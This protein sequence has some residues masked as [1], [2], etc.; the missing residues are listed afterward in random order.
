MKSEDL[1]EHAVEYIYELVNQDDDWIC[2]E[3]LEIQEEA[4]ICKQTCDN[5]L[6]KDCVIRFLKHYK[7][8]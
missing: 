2:T 6:C 1:L 4:D 7:K 3:L 8:K 5:H